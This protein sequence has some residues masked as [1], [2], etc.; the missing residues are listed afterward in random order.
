VND[1][2]CC[3]YNI[4]ENPFTIFSAIKMKKKEI[5][6]ISLLSLLVFLSF[7]NNSVA[8]PP[9]YVGVKKGDEFIW[10]ASLNMVNLNATG[11]ALFGLTNWT[12]MYEYFLDYFENQTGMGFDFFAGAGMKAVMTNVSDE[13]PHPYMPGFAGSG[14][15]F[16]FYMAYAADNWTLLTAGANMTFPM[17]FIVDP[18]GLNESSIMYAFSGTPLFMPIGYNY[19]MFVDVYETMIGTN[20]YTAGNITAQV[21]GNG[22]KLTLKP[23]LL[24]WMAENMGLPFELGT[25]TD[26]ILTVRWNS[27]GVF[28]YGDVKY[29][30]LTVATAQLVPSEDAIPGFEIAT[31]IGVSITSLLALI[32]IQRKKHK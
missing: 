32:Y 21:Q 24:R 29:G 20:P 1:N 10:T 30:G 9:S 27:N 28:D 6:T 2:F 22:F 3:K 23:P 13:I 7:T 15:Y 18:S 17:V 16:D 19:S 14:L 11:I 26:A 12:Y 8:A 31:L 4:L 25:V 5:F